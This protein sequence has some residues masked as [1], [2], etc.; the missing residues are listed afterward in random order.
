MAKG[1]INAVATWRGQANNPSIVQKVAAERSL[2][3]HHIPCFQAQLR[4]ELCFAKQGIMHAHRVRC[5][6]STSSGK[7]TASLPLRAAR[8]AASFTTLASSAPLKPAQ[9]KNRVQ[10]VEGS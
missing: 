8:N 3:M 6:A 5:T 10:S 9:G 1:Q 7:P 4:S 2:K